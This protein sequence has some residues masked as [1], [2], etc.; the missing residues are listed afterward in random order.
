MFNIALHRIAEAPGKLRVRHTRRRA[1]D[2]D[3]RHIDQLGIVY[4][5]FF[6]ASMGMGAF[7]CGGP[8]LARRLV[9]LET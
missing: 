7:I 6:P 5:V 3:Y 2:T 4:M 9:E 1:N 8:Y